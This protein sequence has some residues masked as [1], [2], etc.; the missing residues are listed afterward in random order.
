MV[1]T[2]RTNEYVPLE[3]RTQIANRES[4]DLFLSI[5]ANASANGKAEGVET[6]FLD[7]ALSPETEAVAARENAPSGRTMSNLAD[8]VKAIALNSKLYESKDF[9]SFVQRSLVQGLRNAT[10]GQDQS[11]RRGSSCS[12]APK[13]RAYGDRS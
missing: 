6:Y 7:F 3:Q 2:R 11:S 8:M 12:S 1:L 4:A 10:E 5:H 13:C 9:A